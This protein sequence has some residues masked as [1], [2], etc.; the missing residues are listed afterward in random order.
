MKKGKIGQ[1]YKKLKV[2]RRFSGQSLKVLNDDE[3]DQLYVVK[4]EKID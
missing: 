3:D 1:K 2:L 4:D